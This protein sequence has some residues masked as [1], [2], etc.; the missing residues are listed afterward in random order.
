MSSCKKVNNKIDSLQDTENGI[1]KQDT[2]FLKNSS[3]VFISPSSSDL[4]RLKKEKG[5][6]FYVIADDSNYYYS[7]AI[8]FLKSQSV[9]F[10]NVDKNTII[11]YKTKSKIEIIPQYQNYWYAVLFN[12]DKYKIVDLVDFESEYS[13]FFKS[14]EL[15]FNDEFKSWKG[16]YLNSDNEK[17]DSYETIINRIGWYKLSIDSSQI[18]FENDK[19]LESE[20]PTESPGGIYIKYNYDYKVSG[21]TLKLYEKTDNIKIAPE[22]ISINKKPDLVLFRKENKYYGISRDITESEGLPN[23]ARSGSKPPFIFV[24]FNK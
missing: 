11:A 12:N 14:S 24:K 16:T 8:E 20:F 22:K 1:S 4:E 10:L 5:K 18:C 21:D 9:N 19:R 2:L 15:K 7:N 17:L 23:A 3:I 13:N 6:D